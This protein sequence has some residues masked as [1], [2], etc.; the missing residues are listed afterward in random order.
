MAAALLPTLAVVVIL[1]THEHLICASDVIG[2]EETHSME[3]V[4][5]QE[6]IETIEAAL[7]GDTGVAFLTMMRSLSMHEPDGTYEPGAVQCARNAKLLQTGDEGR[8]VLTPL[9]WKVSDSIREYLFWEERDRLLHMYDTRPAFAD[10]MFRG[11]R[12]LE[13]GSGL[14]CNL[15][16]LQPIAS[17]VLG[18]E[19][20]PVYV[21]MAS[22][23]TKLAGIEPPR[24]HVGRAERLPLDDASQDVIM[25]L[26]S[27]QYMDFKPV[28]GEIYRVLDAQ[29]VFIAILSPIGLFVKYEIR[30]AWTARDVKRFLRAFLVVAVTYYEQWFD[31][32][33]AW[34]EH[35]NPLK[36]PVHPTRRRMRRL[37]LEAGLVPDEA[38]TE[39]N[40][41]ERIYI[42]R[43][44]K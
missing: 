22:V 11:K 6:Q 19:I 4:L 28:L 34:F 12:V 21:Q 17:D 3:Q 26:G 18:M 40:E 43:K 27:L 38:L 20:E 30:E 9:G 29:G 1:L 14:G 5:S 42:A 2:E 32:R 16:S 36:W 31:R 13:I 33:M 35:R 8:P 25:A 41:H 37:F 39:D 23:L 7:Q 15:F 44:A 10:T 24:V